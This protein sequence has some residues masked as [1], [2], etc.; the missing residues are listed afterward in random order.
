MMRS[1][2]SATLRRRTWSAKTWCGPV[3]N[4]RRGKSSFS[5]TARTFS[6]RSSS[7]NDVE[8]AKTLHQGIEE[9][10]LKGRQLQDLSGAYSGAR[11]TAAP[12]PTGLSSETRQA[13]INSTLSFMVL[14]MAAQ[15][16]KSGAEKRRAWRDLEVMQDE[17]T[18]SQQILRGLL[19]VKRDD[20]D[21]NKSTLND[22]DDGP[23][24]ALA[25]ACAQAIV[26]EQQQQQQPLEQKQQQE[27]GGIRWWLGSR[28]SFAERPTEI[29]A[30][31]AGADKEL[32]Q[33]QALLLPVLQAQLEQTVG[34]AGL[35]PTERDQKRTQEAAVES[36]DEQRLLVD[37]MKE[38]MTVEENDQ[39][40]RVV[41]KRLFSI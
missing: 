7:N 36:D 11:G 39:G 2:V 23:L 6:S 31:S 22:D 33:W 19:H 28:F 32:E 1:S 15:S 27:R 3:N 38:Q 25:K 16:Y 34:D 13:I 5:A 26:R 17:L 21:K 40:E 30:S 18:Q 29:D 10:L 35:T 8:V 12:A 37:L 20:D 14:V 41:K 4:S 9:G 24:T